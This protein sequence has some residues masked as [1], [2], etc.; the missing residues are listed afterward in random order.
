MTKEERFVVNPLIAWFKRQKAAWQVHKPSYGSSATGWDIE[1]RRK[2]QDLL[3]E[4]KYID[5]A[6]L[7]S[8]TGLVTASLAYRRQHFMARKYRSWCHHVCW[9]IG[10]NR[11][12]RDICQILFDYIAR[13]PIFWRHYADNV[14]MKYVYF[15]QG[16]KIT[17][18]P[19]SRILKLADRYAAEA[20][21]EN[22]AERRE[23]AGKLSSTIPPPLRWSQRHL[24][25][26]RTQPQPELIHPIYL[27]FTP[28]QLS[29]H[30][31]P[32]DGEAPIDEHVAYYL[33]SASR[34][35]EFCAAKSSRKRL[36]LKNVKT[37][38]QIQ[39]DEKFW[40]AACWMQLFHDSNRTSLLSAL[41]H[42]CFGPQ[43][44]VDGF[45]DWQACFTGR[46]HLFFEPHLPAPVSYRK[47]LREHISDR[48]FVPYVL[49]A[50]REHGCRFEGPTHADVLVLNETN[51]FGILVESKVNS[52]LSDHISFDLMRNQLARCVDVSLERATRSKR[53]LNVRDPEKTVV[54]L[55]T[56]ELFKK[57]PHSR[58]YGSLFHSYRND[59]QTLARDLPHR[60]SYNWERIAQRIG[61]LTWED[62]K[63][64]LP[65]CCKWLD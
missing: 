52:D 45:A 57:N 21:G 53:P 7:A 59:S 2:N 22:L 13:N 16:R 4:A 51:G 41:M 26:S 64:V 10:T 54:I 5:G 23:I 34:Y 62:C 24:M 58:L 44:P 29:E 8:F 39:R 56:P 42:T 63:A 37:A 3:I 27:P 18:V 12:Q 33:N 15:V 61:W 40:A 14:R 43:P 11:E 55:Q 20:Q 36:S 1:A 9:A 50:A 32:L 28:Q 30:F 47:W 38:C 49:E 35:L 60:T 25:S 31:V 6:F 48:H 19:F 46:L 17:R 65:T